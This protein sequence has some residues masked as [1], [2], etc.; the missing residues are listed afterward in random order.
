MGK[1]GSCSKGIKIRDQ[2]TSK[3]LFICF[4]DKKSSE[5]NA[6]ALVTVQRNALGAYLVDYDISKQNQ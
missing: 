6:H 2:Y 1:L 3:I 5:Y 4:N